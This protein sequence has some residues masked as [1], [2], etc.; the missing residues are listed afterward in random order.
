LSIKILIPVI[1]KSTEDF[2]LSILP[3]YPTSNLLSKTTPKVESRSTVA[4]SKVDG[5]QKKIAPLRI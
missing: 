3:K 1:S 4:A 5:G 2:L